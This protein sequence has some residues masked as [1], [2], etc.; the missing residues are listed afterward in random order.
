M[1]H[2]KNIPIGARYISDTEPELGLGIIKMVADKKVSLF[3]PSAKQIRTYGQ[4][5]APIRRVVFQIGDRVKN[6][7]GEVIEILKVLGGNDEIITY[8]GDGKSF[9]E[10]ELDSSIHF[11]RPEARLFNL[12][13]DKSA[14]FGLRYETLMHEQRLQQNPLRGFLGCR[15]ALIPHQLY[16]ANKVAQYVAPRVLLADEVGLGKTIE[17]GLI[18]SQLWAENKRR[19]P[20][21]RSRRAARRRSRA[22]ARRHRNGR[23]APCRGEFP[24]R[25]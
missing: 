17:A 25:R 11:N 10:T 7:N 20:R 1:S 5:N 22:A 15:L 12:S 6:L 13:F 21:R 16:L 24:R 18:L 8:L 19:S 14:I 9:S 3:F 2:Y 4:N 23:A